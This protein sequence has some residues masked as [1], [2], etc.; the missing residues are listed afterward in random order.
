MTQFCHTTL[1]SWRVSPE[2][3]R[4][5]WTLQ[6]RMIGAARFRCVIFGHLL[7]FAA[8]LALSAMGALPQFL[9]TL[10]IWSL[11]FVSASLLMMEW[12][13]VKLEPA[14]PTYVVRANGLT[15]Y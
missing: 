10:G 2:R 15:E 4:H 8:C 1:A 7:F 13:H 3:L 14:P 12:I 5:E 11:C 9:V 6:R